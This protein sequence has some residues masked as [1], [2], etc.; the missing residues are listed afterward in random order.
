[1]TG[2]T[3]GE[4]ATQKNIALARATVFPAGGTD[5]GQTPAP[6][7][8][9]PAANGSGR[10]DPSFQRR[11]AS[12]LP[13]GRSLL[14]HCCFD[15]FTGEEGTTAPSSIVPAA[16]MG[17]KV[18]LRTRSLRAGPSGARSIPF[19]S[20]GSAGNGEPDGQF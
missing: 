20:T 9:V 13:A 19:A 17:K 1:M 8:R 14:R 5:R 11:Q 10:M 4:R 7:C 12:Q 3:G 18:T 15:L 6:D 2:P 16:G